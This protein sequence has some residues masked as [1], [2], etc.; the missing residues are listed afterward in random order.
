MK[1]AKYFET[2]I[3]NAPLFSFEKLDSSSIQ[4]LISLISELPVKP[5]VQTGL[6][7]HRP[8]EAISCNKEK[9]ILF[10]INDLEKDYKENIEDD[11]LNFDYYVFFSNQ[12]PDALHIKTR[13]FFPNDS[14]N[15]FYGRMI[16][17]IDEDQFLLWIDE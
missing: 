16:Q 11:E 6:T 4:H 3:L 2:K 5:F 7:T 17:R 10:L 9:A 15:I 12:Q 8:E 14:G 1:E 13:L